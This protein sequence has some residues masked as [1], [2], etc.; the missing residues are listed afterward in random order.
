M[1]YFLVLHWFLAVYTLFYIKE[2]LYHTKSLLQTRGLDE[3]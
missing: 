1:G 2:N 3:S